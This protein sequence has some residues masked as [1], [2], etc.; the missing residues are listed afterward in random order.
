M[1]Q[2]VSLTWDDIQRDGHEG[3]GC[4]LSRAIGRA[5]GQEVVVGTYSFA[6][7]DGFKTKRYF[8]PSRAIRFLNYY[9]SYN[10]SLMSRIKRWFYVRP[11]T[12]FLEL[13]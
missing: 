5:T 13:K 12:F 4:P 11:F 1:K 6:L 3:T 8:L 2:L 9:D 10:E 7:M